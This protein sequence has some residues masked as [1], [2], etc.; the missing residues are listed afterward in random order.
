VELKR[1]EDGFIAEVVSWVENTAN[2]K[3]YLTTK[4]VGLPSYAMVLVVMR[5]HVN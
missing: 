5:L 1:K 3:Q 4:S 2:S